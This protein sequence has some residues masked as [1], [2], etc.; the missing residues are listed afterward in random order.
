[1]LYGGDILSLKSKFKNNKTFDNWFGFESGVDITDETKVL[2]RRN[3]VIKRIIFLSNLVFSGLFA[4]LSIGE[5]SNVLLTIV[6]FPLTFIVNAGLKKTINKAPDD[7]NT[8]ELASYIASF[9][10]I[11]I[12]IVIYVKLKFG[13]IVYLQECGYIL[14]YYSL[15][16]CSLYQNKKLMKTVFQW[17]L[18][19]VT[20]LHFTVTYNVIFSEAAKDI[21]ELL[22]VIFVSDVGRD[23]LLRTILLALFMVVLYSIVSIGE[24]MQEE[25]KNELI[26]RRQVQEDFTNVVTKIFDVTLDRA[27]RNN[28]DYENIIIVSKM[29]SNLG[30]LLNLNESDVNEIEQI[31]KI[32]VEKQVNFISTAG[33]NEDEKFALLK[34]QTDLGSIII[35]RLQLERKCEDIIRSTFEGSNNDEFVK[36]MKKIQNEV[37]SQIILIC[38]LYVTMRSIKSYKKAY[39]HKLTIQYMTDQ[40]RVYFDGDIFEHFLRFKDQFEEIYENDKEIRNEA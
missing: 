32:H 19:I 9:Y 20:I 6:L 30:R 22:K 27:S 11:L 37:S 17:T 12:S 13:S 10:M 1:M 28:D 4:L 23:I 18:V 14:L 29:A 35:S 36:K 7:H 39:N 38:E 8:Q 3:N 40:F 25:R 31:A 16:I 26:K 5:S 34:E 21:L 33:G 15:A 24:F 2:Y